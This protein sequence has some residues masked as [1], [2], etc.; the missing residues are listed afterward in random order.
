MNDPVS[1]KPDGRYTVEAI[2]TEKG[3]GSLEGDWN[4]L[5]A[6]SETPNVFMAYGW[7]RAWLRRLLADE[8]CERLQ[9]YVLVIR[10]DESVVGIA[11]LV[12]R[13]VAYFGFVVRKIEFLTLHADYNEVVVGQDVGALTQA[14][15]N[16]MVGSVHDW[17]FV[18]LRELRYD[19]GRL[20]TMEA[21]AADAGLPYRLF[22]ESHGCLYMPID[23]PWSETRKKKHLRFARRASLKFEERACDG[24][25]TRIIGQPHKERD[26]L[27]HIIAVEAKKHVGGVLSGPFIGAYP[28]VF[29][30]LF[31]DLGPRGLIAVVIVEKADQLV[32]WRLLFRCGTKLWD[33]QTAYDRAFVE[34][35]PGTV[36]ICAAIDYG[37]EQGC[38]EFD[39]LRGMDTYKTRWTAQFRR[40]RRMILWNRRWISRLGALAYFKLRLGRRW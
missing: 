18:D 11:P 35:S 39:F 19:S 34:L 14:A 31:D 30:S 9:P 24:F 40:N 27:K 7:F 28:E 32:A 25:R 1:A 16:F 6:E 4:R 38:D 29:Q 20:A 21:A 17:D 3:I 23:A 22:A 12:L 36:L 37:F 13:R 15:M 5:S 2:V 10:R 33:Y 26:L 8:G